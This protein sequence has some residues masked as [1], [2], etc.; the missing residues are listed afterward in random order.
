M[1]P[2][3]IVSQYL[4]NAL[5]GGEEIA[6]SK[7]VS[8]PELRQRTLHLRMPSRTWKWNERAARRGQHRRRSLRR[9]SNT[10]GRLPGCASYGAR[11]GGVMHRIFRV[12][13]GR[14]AEAWMTW[15]SLA[16]LEQLGAVEQSRPSAH[17]RTA[18]ESPTNAL[19]RRHCC[20]ARRRR[21]LGIRRARVG[22]LGGQQRND[23]L[24]LQVR[25]GVLPV[26]HLGSRRLRPLYRRRN[27]PRPRRRHDDYTKVLPGVDPSCVVVQNNSAVI[28]VS[29]RARS[30]SH[31]RARSARRLLP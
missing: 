8:S 12:A 9:P 19:R 3:E 10:R 25:Q 14:I 27:D 6:A 16:L 24:V 1:K 21:R 11:M 30:S 18:H 31:G 26:R 28:T 4:E 29:G 23:Q 22:N 13:D 17:E 20:R 7:F 5:V 2:T 15:D